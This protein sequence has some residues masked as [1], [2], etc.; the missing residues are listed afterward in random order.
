VSSDDRSESA[1]GILPERT[2]A[3]E[4]KHDAAAMRSVRSDVFARG[5]GDDL[6]PRQRTGRREHSSGTLVPRT[7]DKRPRM[8]SY[9]RSALAETRSSSRA[10][11]GS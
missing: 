5:I 4:R 9:A 6:F 10:S 8:R 7:K 2:V 1:F 11:A 3:G